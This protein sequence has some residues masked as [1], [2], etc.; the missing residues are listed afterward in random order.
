MSERKNIDRLFQEKFKDFEVN[1]SE[2]AWVNIEAKLDDKKKRRVIP[3]WW[4]LSGVAAVFLLGFLISKSIYDGGVKTDNPIVNENNSN[5]KDKTNIKDVHS[6]HMKDNEIPNEPNSKP[7][8]QSPIVN[9]NDAGK[10][11]QEKVEDLNKTNNSVSNNAV[12]ET[13]NKVKGSNTSEEKKGTQKSVYS[14]KST[15]AERKAS[16]RRSLKNSSNPE[17]NKASITETAFEKSQDQLAQNPKTKS[18]ES[19]Q[20]QQNNKQPNAEKELVQNDSKDKNNKETP[21]SEDKKTINLD[22]LKGNNNSKVATKETDKKANDTASNKSVAKNELEELLNEKES[23]KKE[24]KKSRWQLTSNVAPVFLGSIESG[25][26]I[27]ST[28]SRNS[29]SYKTDVGFG[30]G[31]SYAVNK[32]FSIRTGLNKVNMSYDTNDIL[33]FTGL[34]AKTLQNVSPIASSKMIHVESSTAATPS[35]SETTLLPFE[36]SFVHKNSGYL[37]QEMG[38]LE[39]PVEMTYNLLDKKFGLK[40]IGGFSTLF[41]QDNKITIVGEDRST[42]LGEANNLNDVH[43]S[44]N[45]GLGIK[46]SFMK[47][48]E[49]NVEPTVK[50]QLNTFN[51]NAGHFKPYL[52]GIYSGI[53]Y[54]F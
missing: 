46:Y 45:L 18:K 15:V 37:K 50:Y 19:N 33:F 25:S 53:S 54:K 41:L 22:D 28:L 20:N 13:S 14:S 4:K 34:Q 9:Q 2:E 3:F 47:S 27:D 12:V 42:V 21:I 6:K 23:K 10:S 51:E 48:F 39:M 29:K 31:V 44:T 5:P 49:F 24:S 52:F 26:P 16:H 7:E 8:N 30:L 17:K 32:K 1:P 35:F 38:Y 11:N 40:I 43:F 36:N